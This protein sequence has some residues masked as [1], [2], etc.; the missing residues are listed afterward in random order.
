MEHI[1]LK[2]I[3][4]DSLSWEITHREVFQT[5]DLYHKPHD[6]FT[7]VRLRSLMFIMSKQ[8]LTVMLNDSL[9]AASQ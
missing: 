4:G 5:G 9:Q 3:L 7:P 2:Q 8:A 6:V 1:L